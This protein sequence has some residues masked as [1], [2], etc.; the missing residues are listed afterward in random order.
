MKH[1]PTVPISL[2]KSPFSC[3]TSTLEPL[4]HPW[5]HHNMLSIQEDSDRSREETSPTRKGRARERALRTPMRWQRRTSQRC[6]PHY[7]RQR[8]ARHLP[9][10][11][12]ASP[13]TG[14]WRRATYTTLTVTKHRETLKFVLWPYGI[15]DSNSV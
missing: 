3:I 10:A 12:S 4:H 8:K 7:K 6:A 15:W 2:S 13:E 1:I 9:A 11:R 5:L 14:G